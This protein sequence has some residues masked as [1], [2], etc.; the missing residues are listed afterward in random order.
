LIAR[1]IQYT[2]CADLA[3]RPRR[4]TCH[5]TRSGICLSLGRDRVGSVNSKFPCA[6]KLRRSF[7]RTLRL[8]GVGDFPSTYLRMTDA[9]VRLRLNNYLQCGDISW[10]KLVEL[11]QNVA[12]RFWCRDIFRKNVRESIVKIAKTWSCPIGPPHIVPESGRAPGHSIIGIG[13]GTGEAQDIPHTRIKFSPK[14]LFP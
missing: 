8:A 2:N 6:L 11:E 4:Q 1:T 3:D 10:M 7:W 13:W 9:I 12:K 14:S 5:D